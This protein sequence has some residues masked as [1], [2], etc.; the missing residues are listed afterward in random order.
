M[1]ILR[2]LAKL[3]LKTPWQGA[4]TKIYCIVDKEVH[5]ISGLYFADYKSKQFAS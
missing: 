2:P 4:Q 1:N 3:I 5:G